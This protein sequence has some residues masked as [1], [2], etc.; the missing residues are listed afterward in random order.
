MAV[1]QRIA[2]GEPNWDTKVNAIIDSV[3]PLTEN[4]ITSSDGIVVSGKMKLQAESFYTVVNVGDKRLV[5]VN[6][7]LATESSFNASVGCTITLP[8]SITCNALIG[9]A[10]YG[11][12]ASF[13]SSGEGIKLQ[14]TSGG[15]SHGW[16]VGNMY[17]IHT[18][19]LLDK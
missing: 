5:E 4:A 12:D 16:N 10:A 7:N 6:L 2:H 1:L 18:L 3:N 19:Y 8:S 13:L 11:P 15:D 17:G 9:G 14:A